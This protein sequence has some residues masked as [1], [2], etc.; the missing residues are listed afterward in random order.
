MS[1]EDCKRSRDQCP[2]SIQHIQNQ[3]RSTCEDII[4]CC[5]QA[6]DETFYQAE[7]SLQVKISFFTGHFYNSFRYR[8][9]GEVVASYTP[10]E[11]SSG[12][13]GVGDE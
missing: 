2:P 11:I 8:H 12:S 1:P 3:I 9:L 4:H 13:G 6:I 5:S 10:I 7:Q